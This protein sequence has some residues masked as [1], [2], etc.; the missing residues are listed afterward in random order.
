M[1]DGRKDPGEEEQRLK[2]SFRFF[3]MDRTV[4]DVI[5]ADSFSWRLERY[6]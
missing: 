4:S 6:L 5:K 3:S 1:Q 2:V